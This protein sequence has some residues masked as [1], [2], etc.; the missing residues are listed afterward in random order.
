MRHPPQYARLTRQ[1]KKGKRLGGSLTA[2]SRRVTSPAGVF[3]LKLAGCMMD[4]AQ[5][6]RRAQVE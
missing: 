3:M 4:A 1:A 5:A 6:K 2:L